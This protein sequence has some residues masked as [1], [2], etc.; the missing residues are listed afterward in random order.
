[1]RTEN[2][3]IHQVS[4][5]RFPDKHPHFSICRYEDFS[6]I[7]YLNNRIHRHNYYFLLLV[8]K[9]SSRHLVDFRSYDIEAGSALLMYPGQVHSWESVDDL[10]GY[11]FFFTD[12][13]FALRYHMNVL[14]AFPFF[15]QEGTP[16]VVIPD[17]RKD[18]MYQ[19]AALMMQEMNEAADDAEAVL[20]SYLNV[21]LIEFRRLFRPDENQPMT[22]VQ[23]KVHEFK[24]LV[25]VNF[26]TMHQVR[27]YADEMALTP[28]YLNRIVREN[29]GQSAGEYIRARLML[30]A[31]R[32]LLHENL[33][34]SEIANQL[35]FSSNTYFGRFFKQR[36][37]VSPD[38]FRRQLR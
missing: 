16:K 1:M 38:Q 36:E 7:N 31:K 5:A 21:L 12:E 15:T 6:A 32:L 2:T 17:D 9:G 14:R 27:D 11:L 30:E 24:K 25:E 26:K 33:T 20:R 19:L 18:R 3:Y 22:Y 35:N 28:N 10:D 29:T 4:C 8:T 23:G 13:F 34:V 37:G